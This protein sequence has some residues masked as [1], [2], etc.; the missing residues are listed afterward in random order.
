[1][2]SLGL[3]LGAIGASA[4]WRGIS[5]TLDGWT[6]M[7]VGGVLF[8]EQAA[9]KIA[10][11]VKRFDSSVTNPSVGRR[12]ALPPMRAYI[13]KTDASHAVDAAGTV[14]LWG[15]TPGSETDTGINVSAYNR[16]ADLTSGAWVW[17]QHNGHGWYFTAGRC[18]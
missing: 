9:R 1:M 10:A 2:S 3:I 15:G 11:V 16:F 18:A 7:V 6:L 12:Q 8:S 13:G 5:P 14:S 4:V 17:V